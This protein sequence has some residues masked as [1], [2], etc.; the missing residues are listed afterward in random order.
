MAKRVQSPSSIKTYKQCPRKYYYQYIENL[1]TSQSIHTVRGRI[2]HSVLEDFFDINVQ[3]RSLPVAQK[4]FREELQRLLVK[5]W[6]KHDKELEQIGILPP[7]RMTYFEESM[8]MLH[9]WLDQ[10][11]EKIRTIQEPLP[12][13]FAHLTPVREKEYRSE[14]H[15]VRGF[16]DAIENI[17]GIVR[18]M[19]YKTSKNF[20]LEDHRLQLAIYA[21]L[22]EEAHQ[23]LPDEVGIYFLK[24]PERTIKATPEMVQE[25]KKTIN[26]IH[27]RTHSEKKEDYPLCI[28]PLCKWSTGQ[29]DF[30]EKCFG[31]QQL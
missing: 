24:G 29:C 2:V 19:D 27:L 14:S 12:K 28:T 30:Y 18:I 8:L 20:A 15:A 17:Q 1:P 5:Y 21:L 25:A 10:F 13:A 11:M 23:Q 16:I 26:L 4:L 31:K 3:D 7:E 22:Y 6:R 9:N